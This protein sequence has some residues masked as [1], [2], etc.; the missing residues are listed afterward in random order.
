MKPFDIELAKAGHSVCLK[1]GKK[2]RVICFDVKQQGYPVI[3]LVEE[4]GKEVVMSYTEKGQTCAYPSAYDLMMA[5]EKKTGWINI[6]DSKEPYVYCAKVYPTEMEAIADVLDVEDYIAT[7]QIE[8][9][10]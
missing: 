10:E 5:S 3:A 4:D 7:I 9:G 8:W 6:M 1:N 2:A